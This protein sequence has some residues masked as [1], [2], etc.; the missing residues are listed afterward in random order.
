MKNK[1]W[2]KVVVT[3]AA[4]GV[5]YILSIFA[6]QTPAIVERFYSQG[7]Y[8][9]YS[10]VVSTITG[11]VPVSIAELLLL[12][13]LPALCIWTVIMLVKKRINWQRVVSGLLTL[14]CCVYL[15]FQVGWA[16]N[17][18]RLPYATIAGLHTQPVETDTLE[19]LVAELAQQA[20]Q[21]RGELME[22]EQPFAIVGPRQQVMRQVNEA[23][24]NAQVKYP[25]LSGHYGAPKMAL[26][27]TPLAYLNIAGIF[28]PFTIEAHVNAREADVML[29]ATAMHEAAHLRGFAR[30]DEA[31][32]IAYIVCMESDDVYVQYSGTLLALTYAG[33]A[34][35]DADRA[36]YSDVYSTYDAG[37]ISDLRE[38][39]LNWKPYKGKVAEVQ[40]QINDAYLK[41]NDQADGIK[42]YGRMIDLMIAQMKKDRGE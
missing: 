23:Y 16:Y 18:H 40:D 13:G 5:A 7:F 38:Y 39:H 37:V 1:P 24:Q 33:N 2:L 17:Y 25:W 19:E 36:R 11:L 9:V 12:I 28:L 30:E 20:N 42:S 14:V 29:A 8:K 41:A 34:L 21:L 6:K 15:L 31:N 32:Y 35:A 27:S 4:A 26:L 22:G 10:Q 3:A